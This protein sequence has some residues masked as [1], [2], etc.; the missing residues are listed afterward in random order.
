ME[1]NI[2]SSLPD[3]DNPPVTEVVLGVQFAPLSNFS[4]VH[5]GLYWQS[6]RKDYPNFS[7]QPP[8]DP[9]VERFGT[10]QAKP[11]EVTFSSV[12]PVPRIWCLDGLKNSL[13]QI[14]PDRF[15]HNWRK[16]T[17]TEKYPR[18]NSILPRFISLWKGFLDFSKEE[19]L[20]EIKTNQWEVT[21]VNH[22]LK[23]E[24]WDSMEDV[25]KLF[26]SW[27]NKSSEKYLPVAERIGFNIA[28]S[29]PEELTR[30][31]ITLEPRIRL[32]DQKQLLSLT[33]TAR[34][35]LDSL[36]ISK[37]NEHFNLGHEYIVRGF[38][39]ITT[40]EAHSIWKRK[41]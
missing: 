8:L 22:L 5:L 34:G 7:V 35:M 18:Y 23:G 28:Y 12:P 20:G 11:M 32:S 15:I 30:L 19:N 36:D 39:D 10:D 33:L 2:T 16:V 17:G 1:K 4:A 40:P 3:Y 27:S 37:I 6:I 24:C 13:V 29:F 21:Y 26:C 31:H 41:K 9:V 25:T 38:T 14:Q